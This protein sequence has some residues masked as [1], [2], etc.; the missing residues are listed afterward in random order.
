MAAD[1]RAGRPAF[2]AVRGAC[3]AQVAG[4]AVRDAGLPAAAALAAQAAACLVAAALA[5]LCAPRFAQPA[6]PAWALAQLPFDIMGRP[7]RRLQCVL[8]PLARRYDR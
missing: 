4:D 3:A 6:F 5:V 2:G 7:G 8:S 1:R